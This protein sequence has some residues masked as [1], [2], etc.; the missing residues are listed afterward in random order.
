MCSKEWFHDELDKKLLDTLTF[1]KDGDDY[2]IF[3]NKGENFCS[4]NEEMITF[5]DTEGT[6]CSFAGNVKGSLNVALKYWLRKDLR[7]NLK[8]F[9][10][11]HFERLPSSSEDS[12]EPWSHLQ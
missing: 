12:D 1:V 3:N 7:R 5:H 6:R 11:V 4:F 2:E 9:T 10:S 8:G